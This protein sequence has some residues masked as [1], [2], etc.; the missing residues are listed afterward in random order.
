MGAAITGKPIFKKIFKKS[1]QR[2]NGICTYTYA[3]IYTLVFFKI[4]HLLHFL[5]WV[6]D[7]APFDIKHGLYVK[8]CPKGD[9][10]LPKIEDPARY[11]E[12]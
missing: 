3:L 9:R 2:A 11:I 4:Y 5:S 7:L 8:I 6:N 1:K 12:T 10:Q